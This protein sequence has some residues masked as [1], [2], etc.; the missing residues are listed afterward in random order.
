MSKSVALLLHLNS[1]QHFLRYDLQ[2]YVYV[3]TKQK[4]E[5]QWKDHKPHGK[6]KFT[7]SDGDVYEGQW[8]EDQANG[9]GMYVHSNGAKYQGFWK[10][11]LQHGVGVEIWQDG[12]KY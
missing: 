1:R 10:N 3:C 7:H 11:D 9:L 4:Y 8:A 6:G 5:G 12:S 2:F